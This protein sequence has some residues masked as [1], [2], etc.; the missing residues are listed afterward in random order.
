MTTVVELPSP[1]DRLISAAVKALYSGRG[2][3]SDDVAQAIGIS[4]GTMNARLRCLRSW[5]A[6]EVQ[7]LADYFGVSRDDLY[8][9]LS[10]V[11]LPDPSPTP[12]GSVS[13]PRKARVAVRSLL[14]HKD[15]LTPVVTLGSPLPVAA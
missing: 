6:T 13:N 3:S 4:H 7:G 11:L 2:L 12:G 1:V 5:T 10:G 8:T 15:F 9:G 14:S